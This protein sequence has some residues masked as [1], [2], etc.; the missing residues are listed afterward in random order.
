MCDAYAVWICP[1]VSS[2]PANQQTWQHMCSMYSKPLNL[3]DL[4]LLY[5]LCSRSSQSIKLG[6]SCLWE[7]SEELMGQ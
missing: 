1:F 5:A 2:G 6:T 4:M 3:A 7:S